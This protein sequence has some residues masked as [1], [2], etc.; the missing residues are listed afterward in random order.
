MRYFNR[1]RPIAWFFFLAAFATTL[2]LGSWQVKRLQWKQGVIAEI[3]AA[4][5]QSPL[6]RLPD[7]A[8]ALAPLNFYPVALDG[9]WIDGVEF[10]ISP[11]FYRGKLG[12]FIVTPFALADGRTL[13]VNRGWVPAAQKLPDD[14]PESAVSGEATLHGMLRVGDERN[15]MTPPNNVDKNIWFGRDTLDMANSAGLAN[16]VPAMVDLV[17]TQDSARLPVPSAGTIKLRND[18][19]SYIVTWYG[20]AVSILVI[21]LL[22]HRKKA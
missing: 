5:T 21:F 10:H 20:I 7:D 3:A 19:L 11:R 14:R 18:H 22:Y 16:P 4:Q 9:R 8:A 6:T 13:L 12:Y 17:G 1:P 2:A 15:W